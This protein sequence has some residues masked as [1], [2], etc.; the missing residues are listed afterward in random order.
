MDEDKGS[1]AGEAKTAHTSKARRGICSLY[2]F[3][4]RCLDTYWKAGPQHM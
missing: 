2:P 4:S 1:L 3:S